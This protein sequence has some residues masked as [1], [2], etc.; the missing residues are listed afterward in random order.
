[1]DKDL[2]LLFI[3]ICYIFSMILLINKYKYNK[4]ISSIICHDNNKHIFILLLFIATIAI[5]IYE[6]K[7]KDLYSKILIFTLIIFLFLLIYC[8]ENTILHQLFAFSIF[9]LILLFMFRNLFLTKCN[10]ILLI[11]LLLEIILLL[12]LIIDF[13][14]NIFYFECLYILNF[15][16]YYLYLHFIEKIHGYELT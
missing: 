3:L 4:N 9:I 11:S 13:Y 15:A 6:L 5:I 10:I 8:N 16:L 7:R 1:M 14:Q 2:L 12:F